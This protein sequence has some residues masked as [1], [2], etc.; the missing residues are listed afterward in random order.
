MKSSREV[1]AGQE[2]GDRLGLISIVNCNLQYAKG[3]TDVSAPLTFQ[4]ELLVAISNG[5]V[6][7]GLQRPR[8]F[9]R[10]GRL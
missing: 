4:R 3:Q 6:T 5:T 7:G 2:P 8:S 9:R 1:A 10:I